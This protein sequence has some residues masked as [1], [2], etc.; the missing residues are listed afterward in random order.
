M[1]LLKRDLPEKADIL[2]EPK[3]Y[4]RVRKFGDPELTIAPRMPTYKTTV[5]SIKA[6][7]QCPALSAATLECMHLF[8]VKHNAL[9]SPDAWPLVFR[10]V[11]VLVVRC[12]HSEAKEKEEQ[13]AVDVDAEQH[14]TTQDSDE[15]EVE[16]CANGVERARLPARSIPG[17]GDAHRSEDI[18]GSATIRGASILPHVRKHLPIAKRRLSNNYAVKLAR[19]PDRRG[20]PAMT[21]HFNLEKTYV[22]GNRGE[23]WV[24]PPRVKHHAVRSVL[25]R[26]KNAKQAG[27]TGRESAW[28]GYHRL[29]GEGKRKDGRKLLDN[30]KELYDALITA[31]GGEHCNAT[32]TWTKLKKKYVGPSQLFVKMW[33]EICPTCGM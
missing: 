17:Y 14:P 31:H 29:R 20:F 12:D 26:V 15:D 23:T 2:P 21:E 6:A 24:V 28:I 11:D 5:T 30:G 7:L 1:S 13:L 4:L 9:V 18:V 25:L 32:A 22:Q 3:P 19:V 16:V 33:V 10:D 27:L 8:S